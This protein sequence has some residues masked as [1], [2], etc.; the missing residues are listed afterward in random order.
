MADKKAA[1]NT[2]K[3]QRRTF[4]ERIDKVAVALYWV[5]KTIIL[6]VDWW[7]SH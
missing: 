5:V 6:L 7:L 3:K 2:K 4:L 1:R